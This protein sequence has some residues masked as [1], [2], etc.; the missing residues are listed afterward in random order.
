MMK[1]NPR[2]F[3]R[4]PYN[5]T[6]GSLE[7]AEFTENSDC[8]RF[9]NKVLDMPVT[10]GDRIRGMDDRDLASFLTAITRACADYRCDI[11]PIGKPNCIA[12][13]HWIKQPEGE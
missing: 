10:N 1:C 11:C 2:A 9:N 13:I 7:L 3:A 6:C 12:M 4:C 5:K 8:H